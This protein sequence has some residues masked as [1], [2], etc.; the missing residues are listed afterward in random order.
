MEAQTA[1]GGLLRRT[2]NPTPTTSTSTVR[3]SICPTTTISPT[4]TSPSGSSEHR[5]REWLRPELA[6]AYFEARK[7]KRNTA[8]Q[9]LFE[10]N[11]CMKLVA[12]FWSVVTF[13]YEVGR[14]IAFIIRNT[15]LREV[16][17]AQFVDRIVHHLLYNWLSPIFERQ[18]IYD[19]YSCRKGKE[20]ISVSGAWCIISGV[21]RVIL[22]GPV[23][24]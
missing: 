14:S 1:T 7:N 15:V 24:Y 5:L 10:R 17:A 22:P 3:T 13:C 8:S 23:G 2:M 18:F 20:R 19:S 21:F 6:K 16:F 12:L 4:T 9:S 11:L